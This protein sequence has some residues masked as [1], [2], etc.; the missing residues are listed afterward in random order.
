MRFILVTDLKDW[1]GRF[2]LLARSPVISP[3]NP[4][5]PLQGHLARTHDPR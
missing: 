1:L 5:E 3:A 4:N 2:T